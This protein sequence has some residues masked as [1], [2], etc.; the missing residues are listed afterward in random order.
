MHEAASHEGSFFH[1]VEEVP[2]ISAP[3]IG[4]VGPLTIATST[5]TVMLITLLFVWLAIKAS[6]SKLVPSRFQAA[7]EMFYE[8]VADFIESIVGNK[9]R[10]RVVVPYVG[11]LM[12]YL[13]VANLLPML[14][15][16]AAINITNAEGVHI[17]LFRGATTDFNT[18]FGLALAVI[19][20]MQIVGIKE[21]GF[22]GYASHFIQIKQVW[23]GF[24]KS[25]GEG[26]VSIIGFFVGL[27]EII[28][29]IAKIL[30]LSLRLFGNMFAHEVLTVI[31]LGAFS[32]AGPAIWMGMGLLVGV[33]QSIVFVALVTVYYS[34][35]LKKEGE[36]H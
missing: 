27:I 36:E 4:S 10:A 22:F 32:V 12:T 25:L 28:S 18:T 20:I 30:S 13:L 2:S 16:L 1:I 31:L 23:R 21:Q 8:A 24:K 33:V 3:T 19:V 35:V 5:V 26:A 9:E 17:P 29:E 6:T 14:P 11:A 15:P 34:L 7:L